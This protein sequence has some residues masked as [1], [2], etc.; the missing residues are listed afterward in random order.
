[1]SEK[2][3]ELGIDVFASTVTGNIYQYDDS[4]YSRSKPDTLNKGNKKIIKWG[5][6]NKLPYTYRNILAENDIKQNIIDQDVEIAAGQNLF[7]YEERLVGDKLEIIPVKDDDLEAWLEEWRIHE[8]F[9]E[10]IQDIREMGNSWTEF[11]L[12]R[13]KSKILSMSSLDA[14]DCRLTKNPSTSKR[15]DSELLALAD[16]KNESHINNDLIEVPL[17]DIRN[18]KLGEHTKCALHVRKMT[19]GMPFYQLV[20]W[21]GTMDW[22]EIANIIPKY[23]KQ[24]L[25][26]GASLR[27][28]VKIPK[29]Y[30]KGLSGD[31]LEEKK[32]KVRQEIDGTL[33]G[34]ENAHKALIT[35]IE[36]EVKLG[37]TQFSE[38]KI[39]PIETD[40]KD[41]SYLKLHDQASMVHS[42]G[43]GLD[44]AL[45]GFEA[46]GKMS[47]G[48]EIKNKLNFHIAYK[49]PR[50]RRLAMRPFLMAKNFNFPN[51]KGIKIGVKDMDFTTL[52]VNHSGT[53]PINS[54]V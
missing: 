50:V 32:K 25:K 30:F 52:D 17:L 40:L 47:A 16:W 54:T 6:D 51:K 20:G 12:S 8:L 21:F 42:R 28:M 38:W 4:S 36:D 45:M 34:A 14:T 39:E 7:L 19:S 13:D 48:S 18:P 53:E 41:D 9:T 37:N 29:S 22:A 33:A 35:F 10:T 46:P 44:P 43:H 31:A 2:M 49:T 23:H 15:R 3:V 24:G 5:T 11:I 27:W 26:N 1:M